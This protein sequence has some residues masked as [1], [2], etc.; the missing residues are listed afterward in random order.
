VPKIEEIH[1]KFSDIQI[2]TTGVFEIKE[3]KVT[4]FEDLFKFIDVLF[5]ATRSNYM[6]SR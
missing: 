6:S 4:Y 1:T 5:C 2:K 3:F